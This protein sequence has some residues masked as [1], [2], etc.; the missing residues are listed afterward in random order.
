MDIVS[1]LK[2][3][4]Q[5]PSLSGREQQVASRVRDEFESLGYDKI[6]EDKA[7][8]VCGVRGS[9]DFKILYDA[10]MDVVEP[11][12][13]WAGSPYEPVE[14]DGYLSGRG[15]V[16][17]KGPLASMIYGGAAADVE[18]ITLYVLASVNEEV[19]EG[20][21][22]K[23]FFKETDINPDVVIIGEPSGL[24]VAVGNRGRLGLRIDI[25]GCSAHASDPEAGENAL[26][27]AAEIMLKI[28]D[29]NARLDGES[30]AVTKAS[31]P[32]ENINIIPEK[33]SLFLDYR[34]KPGTEEK[35]IVEKF[36]SLLKEKDN[37]E[38]VTPYYKPWI[39][40]D[41]SPLTWAAVRAQ[42]E[43][44]KRTGTKFWPFC[45]NGSYSAGELKIPT[46]GFGPGKEGECHTSGEKIKINDL[47]EAVKYFS[48]LPRF[49]KE[50]YK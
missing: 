39:M 48:A 1:F 16:D 19:A 33:C 31:T 12:E 45:T 7:G 6:L 40:K 26:L 43:I 14:K 4:I 38:S 15:S 47:K 36:K 49:I 46:F 21:G 35:D 37:V 34:S 2:E 8:N 22:L 17:D 25:A 41:S 24:T 9:G 10:H 3:L 23:Q 20:N 29:L 30:V 42:E 44:F 32:N 27:R 28:K 18:G 50:E 13:G 5:L 11:G